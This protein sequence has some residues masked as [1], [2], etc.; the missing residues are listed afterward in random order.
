MNSGPGLRGRRASILAT[1]ALSLAA[2]GCAA[3]APRQSIEPE[4]V[5]CTDA[6]LVELR[7]AHPDSLSERG[8]QQLQTLERECS[9]ARA[10]A[11]R[12][13]RGRTGDHPMW[14]MASG[15]AMAVMMVAMW[16]SS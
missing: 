13:T 9:A 14:W 8:W 16:S 4:P 15:L 7:A 12:E 10:A 6:S 5:V 1:V 2:A 3:A 11:A